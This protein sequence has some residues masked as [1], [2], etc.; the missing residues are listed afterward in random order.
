MNELV[1]TRPHGEG[2]VEVALNRPEAMN[3]LNMDLLKELTTCFAGL[4][5]DQE[6][7]GIVFTGTGKAFCTGGDLRWGTQHAAETGSGFYELASQFHLAVME[8]RRMKKPVVAAINGLAVGG[9]FSLALACD[10]RI[11]EVSAV[12][13]LGYCSRGL[14]PDGG[15]T[16]NLPKMI[17]HSR[18]LEMA[19]FDNPITPDRALDWGLVT[20]VVEDGHSLSEA[21]SLL[22]QMSE[23][24]L[25]AFA[26][27][28]MLF[29]HSSH[30]TFESQL[31]ME[32]LG[33]RECENHP[34][35]KEGMMAFLE[36]RKPSFSTK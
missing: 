36:K 26:W 17:G 31:E 21:L 10:F 1:I 11:L 15:L 19:A 16:F 3:A 22:Q 27:S 30:T 29:N 25:Q 12:L 34:D 33:L 8:I 23:I 13:R 32:R 24:S 18:A 7:R 4:G 20:R 6:V 2:I 9:G 14:C 35:G 5:V 28:K